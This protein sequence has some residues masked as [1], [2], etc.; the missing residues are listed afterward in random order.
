[1][2]ECSTSCIKYSLF[3]F[4]FVFLIGGLIVVV[5]GVIL[6]TNGTFSFVNNASMAFSVI[7]IIIGVIVFVLAFFGCCGAMRE[8]PWKLILYGVLVIL[9]FLIEVAAIGIAFGFKDK[10]ETFMKDNMKKSIKDKEKGV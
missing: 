6:H 8:A 1:M 9:I 5:L 3:L 4:N 7:V 10:T 2:G